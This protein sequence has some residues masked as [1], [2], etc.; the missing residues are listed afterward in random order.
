MYL[1]LRIEI[2]NVCKYVR[3]LQTKSEEHLS[4]LAGDKSWVCGWHSYFGSEQYQFIY[5]EVGLNW[6][7]SCFILI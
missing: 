3:G 1:Y 7:K 6:R 2:H 5:F 4:L